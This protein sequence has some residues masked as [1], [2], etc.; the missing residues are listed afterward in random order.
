MGWKRLRPDSEVSRVSFKLQHFNGGIARPQADGE[1][2]AGEISD[3]RGGRRVHPERDRERCS[4]KMHVLVSLDS[5]RDLV[6]GTLP[7]SIPSS[8][9]HSLTDRYGSIQYRST[10]FTADGIKRVDV[11][12]RLSP[13]VALARMAGLSVAPGSLIGPGQIVTVSVPPKTTSAPALS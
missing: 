3:S 8:R 4:G 13:V 2:S 9:L 6:H 10:S 12:V 1:L 11:V 7:S 5:C